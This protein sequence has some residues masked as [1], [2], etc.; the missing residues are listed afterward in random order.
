M[1]FLLKYQK[2]LTFL[3]KNPNKVVTFF[4]VLL[5]GITDMPKNHHAELCED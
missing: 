2:L 4:S 5:Y 3:V 1:F